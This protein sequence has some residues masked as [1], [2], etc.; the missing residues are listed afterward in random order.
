MKPAAAAGFDCGL[1]GLRPAM[2]PA[3]AAGFDCGLV[4][5]RPR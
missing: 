5:L 4:G 1:A 3:A 2:T